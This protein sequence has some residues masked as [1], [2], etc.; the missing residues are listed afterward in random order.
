[1]QALGDLHRSR[2]CWG[3][4]A[5]ERPLEAVVLRSDKIPIRST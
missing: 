1:M 4:D 2:T 5:A 3:G